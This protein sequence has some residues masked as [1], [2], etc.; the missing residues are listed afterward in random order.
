MSTITY[1]PIETFTFRGVSVERHEPDFNDLAWQTFTFLTPGLDV[2]H[3][4]PN[5]QIARCLIDRLGKHRLFRFGT[6]YANPCAVVRS[7]HATDTFLRYA[8]RFQADWF[9]CFNE[10]LFS[11]TRVRR[12]MSLEDRVTRQLMYTGVLII[13]DKH[14]FP[15]RWPGRPPLS[16]GTRFGCLVVLEPLP[17]AMVR[18]M[19]DC[20]KVVI[21]HRKHLISGGTKSCGC[22]KE[23]REERLKNRRR[24]RGWKHTGTLEL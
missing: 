15:D 4:G 1:S 22:R 9:H 13:E 19:C 6:V 14:I 18:C 20:G 11:A 16:R 12:Q 7:E 23:Q 5:D 2:E 17:Q 21:K 24:D 10:S 3:P 8:R